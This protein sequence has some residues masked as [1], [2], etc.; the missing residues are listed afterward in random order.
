MLVGCNSLFPRLVRAH[1]EQESLPL[2]S[3]RKYGA[4]EE[5]SNQDRPG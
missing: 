1:T 5:A 3:N 2:A 4:V